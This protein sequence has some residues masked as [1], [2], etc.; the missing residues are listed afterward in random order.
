MVVPAGFST[1]TDT[2]PI[3][4][5]VGMEFVGR[6]WSEPTLIKLAYAFEQ[7]SQLRQPP[8]STPLLKTK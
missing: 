8:R 3:G 6:P 5:P 2:A 4:V 1:P 7:A